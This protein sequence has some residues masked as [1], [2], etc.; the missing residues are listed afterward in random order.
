MQSH[1]GVG[2]VERAADIIAQFAVDPVPLEGLRDLIVGID[3]A[4]I[5][6]QESRSRPLH[7]GRG[8]GSGIND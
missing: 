7:P 3:R 4:V 5:P 6:E 8:S 2:V 1:E